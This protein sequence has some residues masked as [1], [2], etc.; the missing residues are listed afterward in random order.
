MK[1]EFTPFK[2][3]PRHYRDV[4]ITEKI[5][6]TNA[7]VTITEDGEIYAA[8]RNR[9]ITVDDDNYGFAKWVEDNKSDLMSLGVGTHFGEWWGQGIQRDYGLNEKRFSL[10]N[11]GRWHKGISV[12]DGSVE[13]PKCCYVVPLL[14][15][16]SNKDETYRLATERLQSYGS[17]AK[18]GYNNPEGWIAYHT[19]SGTLSK[20]TFDGDGHKREGK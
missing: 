18:P 17:M 1:P 11:V 9:W 5:D 2:K 20:F 16:G 10:F 19:K 12:A 6:G 3:I 8:S 7:S 14:N 13:C 4:I 15:F